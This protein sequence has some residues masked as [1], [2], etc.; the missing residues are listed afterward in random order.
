MSPSTEL[1]SS[2]PHNMAGKTLLEYLCA[3]FRYRDEAAWAQA[4]ALG[5]VTLNGEAVSSHRRLHAQDLVSTTVVLK[6]PPVD[7]GIE[8]LHQD[9]GLVV[10]FKPG[11]LPSH[12]DGNFITKTFIALLNKK[13]GP[14]T[15]AKLIHRLDRE[16]SGVMVAALDPKVHRH[17]A[18]QFERSE[19]KK[20]YLAISQGLVKDPTFNVEGDILPDP[21]SQ[22]TIRHGLFPA[23]TL[24]GKSSLTE[25]EVLS[26]HKTCTLLRC[27]P[28]TG[29]T[30]QIRV[31]LNSVGHPIV[32]DKLY[33]RTDQEFLDWIAHMKSGGDPGYCPPMPLR[34]H[35]LHAHKI[36][37]YHPLMEK[38]V[39]Y[40][41]EVPGDMKG[42]L[43][44][45]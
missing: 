7:E 15:P 31:H 37:F 39:T 29:R 21:S 40:E 42:Y 33:G 38:M 18:G 25:F 34:R 6:E 43:E 1:K 14:H 24:G 30:N 19:V 44:G 12:A 41:A 20:E 10:A 13:L 3:R 2:V 4:I 16:T 23:G 27:L 32:G 36:S 17:I 26:Q 35:C 8:I 28:R 9:A 22:L 5:E 11:G 45:H